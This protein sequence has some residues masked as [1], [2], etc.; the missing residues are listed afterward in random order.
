[1]N[2]LVLMSYMIL[3]TFPWVYFISGL[4]IIVDFQCFEFFEYKELACPTE[5][6]PASGGLNSMLFMRLVFLEGQDFGLVR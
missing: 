1:M 6:R 2:I 5:L 3:I 4:V